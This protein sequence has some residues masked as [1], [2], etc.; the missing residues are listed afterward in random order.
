[1]DSGDVI[2]TLNF[3]KNV[4]TNSNYSLGDYTVMISYKTIYPPTI[5]MIKLNIVP[6][7]TH[8]VIIISF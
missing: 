6:I 8:S 7:K 4:E 1:M 5:T 3:T 2:Y